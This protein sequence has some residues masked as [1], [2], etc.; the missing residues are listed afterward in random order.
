MSSTAKVFD[1]FSCFEQVSE[2]NCQAAGVLQQLLTSSDQREERVAAIRQLEHD[3]DRLT[4]TALDQLNRTFITPLE[5]EDI[6]GLAT[7]L[8]DILDLMYAAAGRVLMYRLLKVPTALSDMAGILVESVAEV[9]KVVRCLRDPKDRARVME[10][11]VEINRIENN[12]DDKLRAGLG[13][14]FDT[15]K[16]PIEL[17]KAKEILE[18]VEN[19]TD[20]CE[21]VA[22]LIQGMIVKHS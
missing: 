9:R 14:L 11:C 15:E 22:N 17:I 12:A 10:I 1:F 18:T 13:Q 21:R 6:H 20:A 8:D 3:A 5:R 7:S 4:H 16:D 2:L 19:A